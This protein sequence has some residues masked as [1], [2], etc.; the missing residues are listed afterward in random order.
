MSVHNLTTKAF[1][2]EFWLWRYIILIHDKHNYELY[3][4]SRPMD[5][6]GVNI[7]LHYWTVR[8]DVYNQ[9]DW[10]LWA[11]EDFWE[12]ISMDELMLPEN[13]DVRTAIKIKQENF[14]P[15]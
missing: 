9:K 6:N 8:K 5:R 3:E 15:F 12:E 14:Y 2:T 10:T 4:M 1:A 11:I 13:L 7:N